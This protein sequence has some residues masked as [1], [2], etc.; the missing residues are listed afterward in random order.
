MS[1]YE[2]AIS[3]LDLLLETNGNDAVKNKFKEKVKSIFLKIYAINYI[4]N[5]IEVK[6][7]FY[8]DYF[9]ITFSCLIESY[10]LLLNNYPRGALLVLRS[11]LENFVKHIIYILNES[12]GHT[13]DINDR[14]YTANKVT[15][16]EIID[17][18]YDIILKTECIRLN[19][20]MEN[21]YKKLSGLSHSLVPESKNSIINYFSDIKIINEDNINLTL[22]KISNI[23]ESIFSFCIIICQASI[24]NWESIQLEKVFRLVFGI[25]K[26][27]TYIEL[28]KENRKQ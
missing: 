10:T 4:T 24:K 23:A 27:E 17:K 5:R 2:D 8:S 12:N 25:R 26:T 19:S 20:R 3:Q 15:L 7:N 6:E 1:Y 13:Y 11:S 28:L 22:E 9:K 21:E 16:D 14:S 18:T